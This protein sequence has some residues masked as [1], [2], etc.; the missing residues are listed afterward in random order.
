MKQLTFVLSLLLIFCVL[1]MNAQRNNFQETI[2]KGK[3]DLLEILGNQQFNLGVDAEQLKEAKGMNGIPF[4]LMNFDALLN[5]RSG[6]IE[7]LI[8]ERQKMVVPLVNNQRV[9]TT[10]SLQEKRPGNF[11][12][13]ELV[14]PEYTSELNILSAVTQNGYSNIRIVEVPNLRATLYLVDDKIFTSYDGRDLRQP[15]E[16]ESLLRELQKEAREFQSKYGD[17][18]KRG[19]LVD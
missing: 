17:L 10:I 19:K 9:V 3:S 2:E 8:K 15:Q 5:Y 1:T 11:E 4:H 16:V 7:P 12:I 18:L 13:S 6:N 14:I